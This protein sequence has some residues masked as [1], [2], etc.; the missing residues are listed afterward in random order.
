MRFESTIINNEG[1]ATNVASPLLQTLY[2]KNLMRSKVIKILVSL[3]FLLTLAVAIG[4]WFISQAFTNEDTAT[5][6]DKVAIDGGNH[7]LALYRQ[8]MWDGNIWQVF[9]VKNTPLPSVPSMNAEIKI[10]GK[11]ITYKFEASD[12]DD[13]GP[14][15]LKPNG[16][17]NVLFCSASSCWEIQCLSSQ[18]E[19]TVN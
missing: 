8:R 7:S 6:I 19:C 13:P 11:Q 17:N 1:R 12:H 18:N 15:Y 2:I 10:E 4:Y 9:E 16:Q 5:L 14:Y 3:V